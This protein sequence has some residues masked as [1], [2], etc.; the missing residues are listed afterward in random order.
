[1][2]PPIGSRQG[3]RQTRPA[4]GP[5]PSHNASTSG[6][7]SRK[8]RAS[9][10]AV[11]SSAGT[12]I[13][14][15]GAGSPRRRRRHR[16]RLGRIPSAPPTAPCTVTSEVPRGACWEAGGFSARAKRRGRPP[17][18]GADWP[19]PFGADLDRLHSLARWR[20]PWQRRNRQVTTRCEYERQLRFGYERQLKHMSRNS[21]YYEMHPIYLELSMSYL[22]V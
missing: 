5:A 8:R 2:W 18:F 12:P 4:S 22:L 15:S 14:M 21:A 9:V 10:E 11:A 6:S 7:D 19:P 3:R 20:Y 13:L 16:L 17:P 1:M